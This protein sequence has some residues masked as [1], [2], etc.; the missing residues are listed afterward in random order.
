MIRK[1]DRV[2]SVDIPRPVRV[3]LLGQ[4]DPVTYIDKTD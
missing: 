3:S 2:Q 1:R 4:G